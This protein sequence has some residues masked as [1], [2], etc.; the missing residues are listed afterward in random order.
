MA[1]LVID[2]HERVSTA[3]IVAMAQVHVSASNE[4]PV[5]VGN[6]TAEIVTNVRGCPD[7]N[8]DNIVDLSDLTLGMASYLLHV[9][10]PGYNPLADQNGDGTITLQD[11]T[12]MS[13]RY[14]DTC[15][16]LD[17]D[18]DGLSDYDEVHAYGTDPYRSDTDGDGLPDGVEVW[19]YSSNPLI[20]DTDGDGYSDSEEAALGKDPRVFCWIMR[21]DVSHDGIVDLADLT[22]AASSYLKSTGEIGFQPR[23]DSDA[24]GIVDL[25]DLT[26]I[27]LYYLQSVQGCT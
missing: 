10:D 25:S 26:I 3:G 9:G 2:V 18:H 8:G 14:L 6:N 4:P 11:L 22:I 12:V 5:N 1:G 21:T 24:N 17:S 19:T 15:K 7:L 13:G 16:G 23:A 20:A 27:A